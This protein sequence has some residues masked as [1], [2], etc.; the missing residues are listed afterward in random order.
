MLVR[1]S[2]ASAKACFGHT[3]GTAGIHGSLTAVL[4]RR[5]QAAPPVMQNRNLNPYVASAF[6]EWLSV[7]QNVLPSVP[8]ERATW[9]AAPSKLAACSSFGMSGVNAHALLSTPHYYV[10]A[11]KLPIW[12]RQH[13]WPI[14]SP[15]HMLVS[16]AYD[17]FTTA[18]R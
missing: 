9:A 16:A 12:Q 2:A 3:E 8:R 10:V 15:H 11:D 1:A 18:A 4:A 13:R 14:V 5:Q 7:K 17:Q 6:A